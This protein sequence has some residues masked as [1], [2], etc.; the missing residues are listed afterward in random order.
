MRLFEI[1]ED[2]SVQLNKPWIFLVPELAELLK[3]DKRSEG[4]YRGDKK[5]R[6]IAEFTF[7]YFY[8]DFSSPIRDWEDNERQK[9]AEYYAGEKL[10]EFG[11]DD[12][13]WIAQKKYHE[14]QLAASRPLRTLKSLYKGMEAMD[15][16]FENIDFTLK[17]KMGKLLN[18]PSAFVIN[19]SKLNKMYD[20]VRNFEKRVEDDLKQSVSGIRGPNSTLGDQEGQTKPWSEQG[21]LDGSVH[22][23]GETP[24]VSTSFAAVLEVTKK[25]AISE[26]RESEEKLRQLEAVDETKRAEGVAE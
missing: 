25:L 11:L 9:E 18:D 23:A 1:G 5:L 16:Y 15:S 24:K 2:R 3:R 8:T 19:A 10:K 13:V 22:A 12:K 26:K 7:I 20:E 21:I 17:D 4:D 6:A 14:L